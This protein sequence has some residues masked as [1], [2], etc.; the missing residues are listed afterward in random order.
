MS[1]PVPAPPAWLAQLR[2][3]CGTAAA[4]ARTAADAVN[5][6]MIR[7][8]CEAMGERNPAVPR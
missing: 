7:R 8:W 2:Q 3:R 4:V 5:V 1:A 6:P